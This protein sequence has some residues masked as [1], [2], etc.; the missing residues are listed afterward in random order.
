MLTGVL[1]GESLRLGGELNGIPLRVTRIWRGAT[2]SATADQPDVWTLMDFAAPDADAEPL[3]EALSRCLE[4]H[5][6]WYA[7]FNTEAEAFVVFADRVFRYPRGN[8]AGRAE[9]QAYG[10]SVGVPEP[11]LDWGEDW[12][13]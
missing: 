4:P 1:I 8:T 13:D 7:N 3:A 6:G 12:G 11:Q 9:A 5:G 2:A 10:R